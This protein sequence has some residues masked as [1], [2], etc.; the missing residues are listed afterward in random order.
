M[1]AEQ[2]GERMIDKPQLVVSLVVVSDDPET[3]TRSMETMGRAA[4]GLALEGINA[5]L[6]ATHVPD[7]DEDGR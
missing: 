5:N 7:D 1:A 2:G 6:S 3:I 4:A